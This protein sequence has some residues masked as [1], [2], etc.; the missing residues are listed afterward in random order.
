MMMLVADT[1]VLVSAIVFGGKPRQILL[2][3]EAGYL[4]LALSPALLNELKGV[5]TRPK[6]GFNVAQAEAAA[7][8]IMNLAATVFPVLRLHHVS[9]DPDDNRVLEC[10]VASRAQVIVSG[11]RHLLDLL[12][13]RQIPVMTPADFTAYFGATLKKIS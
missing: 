7:V 5:L 9:Q 11:D 6:I 4:Q 2:W 1:N 12:A 13:Y 8:E 10:A 3:A